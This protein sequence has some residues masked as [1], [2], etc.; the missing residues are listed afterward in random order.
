MMWFL[1]LTLYLVKT[2]V[3]EDMLELIVLWSQICQFLNAYVFNHR[4]IKKTGQ[5]TIKRFSMT[6]LGWSSGSLEL[7]IVEKR[8]GKEETDF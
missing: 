7:W 3:R 4:K 2:T 6:E 8:P 1:H 5:A